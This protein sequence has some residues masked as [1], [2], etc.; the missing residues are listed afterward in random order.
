MGVAVAIAILSFIAVGV[1]GWI[2]T[3][4]RAWVDRRNVY[5][6]LRSNTKDEPRESH[7]D[8]ATLAKGVRLPEDRIRRACMSDK[9]IYRFCK[10]SEQWSVWREEPQSI[11]EK[12]GPIVF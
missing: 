6:W 11:Y 2:I 12:R 5:L 8:T 4:I 9:R 7:V 1:I 3:K 10:D